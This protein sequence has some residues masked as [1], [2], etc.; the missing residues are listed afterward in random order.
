[1]NRYSIITSVAIIGIV[2][3]FAISA[4]NIAGA[5]HTEYR[6]AGGTSEEV[7]SFFAMSTQGEI[8]F[9]NTLPIGVSFEKFEV[10]PIYRG[11]P[12]GAYTIKHITLDPLSSTVKHGTFTSKNLMAD[13]HLFMNFDY[14]FN[15]GDMRVNPDHFTVMIKV[16]TP[17]LG[18]IPYSTT[19]YVPGAEFDRMM[20]KDVL[21][22]G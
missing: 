15:E 17:I 18:L 2:V 10:T 20:Q 13:R 5:Q 22:C 11:E 3:P 9:C 7:F 12:T 6:W 14:E 21:V 1:M 19:F 4:I 16:D 8:E